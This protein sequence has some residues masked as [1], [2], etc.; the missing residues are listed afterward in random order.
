MTP[1]RKY[2]EARVTSGKLSAQLHFHKPQGNPGEST[3]GT[4]MVELTT[5]TTPI[6]T[7]ESLESFVAEVKAVAEEEAKQSGGGLP[8]GS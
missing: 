2:V 5:E 4:T 3:E 8:D 7:L 6:L 1:V